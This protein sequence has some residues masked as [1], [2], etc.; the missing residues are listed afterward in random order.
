MECDC[1]KS[2]LM[3]FFYLYSLEMYESMFIF[4]FQLSVRVGDLVRLLDWR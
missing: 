2:W 3:D 1:V 4:T